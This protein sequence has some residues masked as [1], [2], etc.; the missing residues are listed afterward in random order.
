[1]TNDMIAVVSNR[2]EILRP[3]KCDAKDDQQV[4]ATSFPLTEKEKK[5]NPKATI[6]HKRPETIVQILTNYKNLALNKTRE[7]VKGDSGSCGQCT[8]W[9]LRKHDK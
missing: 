1:M 7:R 8:L 2:E 3:S 4:W 6:T 5:L 9:L